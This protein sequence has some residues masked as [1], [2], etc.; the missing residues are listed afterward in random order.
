MFEMMNQQALMVGAARRRELAAE[1]M[2]DARM[3]SAATQA[4]G[5]ALVAVGQRMAD[6]FPSG[7]SAKPCVDCA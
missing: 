4:V 2:R 5:V 1:A 3:G 7:R 6:E